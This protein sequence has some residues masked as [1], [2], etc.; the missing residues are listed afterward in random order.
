MRRPHPSTAQLSEVAPNQQLHT[1]QVRRVL[2][3]VNYPLGGIRSYLLNNLPHIA[4]SGYEYTF[5]APDNSAFADLK[6]DVQD[7]PGVEFIDIPVRRRKYSICREVWRTLQDRRFKLIHSQG[8]RAGAET[9][10]AN[11]AFRV[12]HI[13][14]LHDTRDPRDFRG[15]LAGPKRKLVERTAITASKIIAVSNDC[16][17]NHLDFFAY[18]KKHSDRFMVIVNGVDVPAL[19]SMAEVGR[20]K[21]KPAG[22]PYALGYFGRFMPEKGFPVLLDALKLLGARGYQDKIRLITT[23]DPYGYG[24][25]YRREVEADPILRNMIQFVAPVSQIAGIMSQIDLLV[26][27][28]LREACPLLPM[29][30]MVLGVP[31]VGSNAI[32]L[33]EVLRDT[34]S[35]TP[36]AG[37]EIA[38]ADAIVAAIQSPATQSAAAYRPE[39]ARRF[40]IRL[41]AENL[42]ILYRSLCSNAR[43]HYRTNICRDNCGIGLRMSIND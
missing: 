8:L 1:G 27:P 4:T 16:L 17:Q 20:C 37:S 42:A 41:A 25:E 6:T 28:S 15:W 32:G 29:E 39:A 24:R 33:R 14:T 3:V 31:V 30:A 9:A 36:E 13:I 5:L 7:W 12:P 11:L 38:L 18:W 23:D 43:Q 21:V 19:E 10:L 22:A 35:L 40:D 26:T 2:I 34:P